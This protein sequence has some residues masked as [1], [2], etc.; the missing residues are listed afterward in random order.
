MGGP[1]DEIARR[2]ESDFFRAADYRRTKIGI[3]SGDQYDGIPPAHGSG[4][5][6]RRHWRY[7]AGNTTH[8][9]S[10]AADRSARRL[11]FAQTRDS[12]AARAAET[13]KGGRLP[14]SRA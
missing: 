2:G 5:A 8:P 7:R 11:E 3:R 13:G 6:G 12:F 10:K 9:E 1:R 4:V 14:G